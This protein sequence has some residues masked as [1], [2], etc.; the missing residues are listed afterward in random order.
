MSSVPSPTRSSGMPI[1]FPATPFMR[2]RPYS[3]QLPAGKRP[4]SLPADQAIKTANLDY[5]EHWS[6]DG[7][8]LQVRHDMTTKFDS[9]L[10]SGQTRT[11]LLAA[12]QK[13]SDS[14][15]TEIALVGAK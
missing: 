5:V 15:K 11:D 13:I 10:C 9:P 7:Q 12:L 3:L 8:V 14:F 4:A 2:S 6:L 1:P